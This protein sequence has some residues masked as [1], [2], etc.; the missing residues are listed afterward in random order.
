MDISHST[1]AVSYHCNVCG[2]TFGKKCTLTMHMSI[3]GTDDK[4]AFDSMERPS[5]RSSRFRT[6]AS[7]SS[8]PLKEKKTDITENYISR[9]N[10]TNSNSDVKIITKSSAKDN[11]LCNV[12]I[13]SV[14]ST[15]K[16]R[17]HHNTRSTTRNNNQISKDIFPN[18][19]A[20]KVKY[21]EP[22]AI[23]GNNSS[24][25]SEASEDSNLHVE[26]DNNNIKSYTVSVDKKHKYNLGYVASENICAIKGNV[27]DNLGNPTVNQTNSSHESDKENTD[28]QEDIIINNNLN[29]KFAIAKH[30][31]DHIAYVKG[32]ENIK[33]VNKVVAIQTSIENQ[34]KNIVHSTNIN[35]NNKLPTTIQD[36]AVSLIN[37][38]SANKAQIGT[39]QN[40]STESNSDN[41]K[42]SNPQTIVIVIR[43]AKRLKNDSGEA[44]STVGT[45]LPISGVQNQQIISS[46]AFQSIIQHK[47]AMIENNNLIKTIVSEN[48]NKPI[49]CRTV[50]SVAPSIIPRTGQPQQFHSQFH[51]QYPVAPLKNMVTIKSEPLERGD[52]D[53]S[54]YSGDGETT[55]SDD[56]S[57]EY[58]PIRKSARLDGKIPSWKK[59]LT[60]DSEI[61][62]DLVEQPRVRKRKVGRPKLQDIDDSEDGELSGAAEEL[63]GDV[64][65]EMDINEQE[66]QDMSS[67]LFAR[68]PRMYKDE[69]SCEI[70]DKSF[71]TEKYL[72]MHSSLH[73]AST[74]ARNLVAENYKVNELRD[75]DGYR[76]SWTCKICNK[77]FAQNSSFKNHMRT[78]SDER[79]FVCDICCIG[80]K[81]RYHLKKHMLFKHSDE[82]KEKCQFCGKKFKDSTAVRAHERIH[83]DHR[84]YPCR[85][86]GKAFKTSECLWHHENRS[87]TCGA[88]GGPPLPPL[89]KKG[90][91][92]RK[93]K[94][95]LQE[96]Q[97]EERN[98][99]AALKKEE[100]NMLDLVQQLIHDDS[101]QLAKEQLIAVNSIT[102]QPSSI[103]SI[104]QPVIIPAKN[105]HYAVPIQQLQGHV[106]NISRSNYISNVSSTLPA[107]TPQHQMYIHPMHSGNI[108][109]SHVVPSSTAT[110][111]TPVLQNSTSNTQPQQMHTVKF[112]QGQ[113]LVFSVPV[114]KDGNMDPA[115]Q[116]TK[117]ILDAI[118][119][120]TGNMKGNVNIQ[121]T[122]QCAVNNVQEAF[123]PSSGVT[124]T[125]Q[126]I[127]QPRVAIPISSELS[128]KSVN[129]ALDLSNQTKPVS[130]HHVYVR[131][132]TVSHDHVKPQLNNFMGSQYNRQHFSV[133]QPPTTQIVNAVS[134]VVQQPAYR[135]EQQPLYV[136]SKAPAVGTSKPYL[137]SILPPIASVAETLHPTTIKTEIP[138]QVAEDDY[139][140]DSGDEDDLEDSIPPA[141][142]TVIENKVF[143]SIAG[144][145]IRPVA[146]VQP[147]RRIELPDIKPNILQLDHGVIE[148]TSEPYIVH[149]TRT[150]QSNY[151]CPKCQK[152]FAVLSAF[153]KHL[154]KHEEVRPFRCETCDIGFKLKVHLKKHNLYRHSL[155]YPCECSICGKRF[156]DSSAVRLHERIHSEDR[157]FQCGCG[158]SFKTKENLWG[159]QNRKMCPFA[160][161][162]P[163]SHDETNQYYDASNKAHYEQSSP[164]HAHARL[165]DG[166]VTAHAYVKS[167]SNKIIAEAVVSNKHVTAQAS[168]DRYGEVTAHASVF[169]INGSRKP[170][171]YENDVKT[172]SFYPSTIKQLPSDHKAILKTENGEIHCSVSL[173]STVTSSNLQQSQLPS[174]ATFAT[175]V[176]PP[177]RESDVGYTHLVT[178]ESDICTSLNG[179]IQIKKESIADQCPTIQNLLKRGPRSVTKLPGIQ[180]LFKQHIKPP[181][182]YPGHVTPPRYSDNSSYGS[183]SPVSSPTQTG[184]PSSPVSS[185]Y[186]RQNSRSPITPCS[187]NLNVMLNPDQLFASGITRDPF[188]RTPPPPL[189][190]KSDSYSSSS[191]DYSPSSSGTP[192]SP[193]ISHAVSPAPSAGDGCAPPV[194]YWDDESERKPVVAQWQQT[195]SDTLFHEL[196]NSMINQL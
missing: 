48:S 178:S 162:P 2:K 90:R 78:H 15:S 74:P 196:S 110:I 20:L 138:D 47:R 150:K 130:Q 182:P 6:V 28:S 102:S 179:S 21:I 151:T 71:T 114:L 177:S 67:S 175:S 165:E 105:T 124:T 38:V 39:I 49:I 152:G 136:M 137:V 22:A 1:K 106:S 127:A 135:Q 121:K 82:L 60:R 122:I 65:A 188:L 112:N 140:T 24:L 164:I 54:H 99:A 117:A 23:H 37:T 195:D 30:V 88:L 8:S 27:N 97:N 142:S 131:N 36:R 18:S 69:Y 75:V 120:T 185:T 11:T 85:R 143:T 3:H 61:L 80:F 41:I 95:L 53:V 104:Q 146:A 168:I 12:E 31:S 87:K 34:E 139:S 141:V 144:G 55:E 83:S 68:R 4:K 66:I 193:R 32:T 194:I 187:N 149:P 50:A 96:S 98:K 113:Q 63:F 190:A 19:D 119:N 157:P 10:V 103:A 59:V 192:R 159:H 118:S 100:D 180:Q 9:D 46:S 25:N 173:P 126:A 64:A 108:S 156:K 184:I 45:A 101:S 40:S 89:P 109:A 62:S 7:V 170:E 133:Q 161:Y 73:G 5:T 123:H 33:Q 43:E 174:F 134:G 42:V 93:N 13:C 163:P 51:S 129:N 29:G 115:A 158:K 145:S 160:G 166:G 111:K 91:M 16:E 81:E 172:S 155:D 94:L 84:P 44:V 86:C 128:M 116:V 183:A 154:L 132:N 171:K 148:S 14:R 189:Y 17:V 76:S 176:R 56:G 52:S 167:L 92:S 35:N 125:V 107:M 181:P 186:S 147:V 72:Q 153:Q 191:S 57:D 77:A 169:P 58:A 26:N 70:C 79:P